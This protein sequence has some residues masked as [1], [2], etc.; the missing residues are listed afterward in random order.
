MIKIWRGV[1][2]VFRHFPS[3]RSE[4]KYSSSNWRGLYIEAAVN[5]VKCVW[6]RGIFI[7]LHREETPGTRNVAKIVLLEMLPEYP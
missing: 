2:S 4:L 1:S 3:L 6:Q 5:E 7:T